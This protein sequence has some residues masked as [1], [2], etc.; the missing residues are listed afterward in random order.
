[1]SQATTIA[2]HSHLYREA[3][4]AITVEQ[5][6]LALMEENLDWVKVAARV[7]ASENT[8]E[9]I[10]AYITRDVL[11]DAADLLA[12]ARKHGMLPPALDKQ[13]PPPTQKPHDD[14]R[15]QCLVCASN[16]PG[17]HGAMEDGTPCTNGKAG[18]A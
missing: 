9:V 14:A 18:A 7:A 6:A 11:I 3:V 16:R 12:V 4:P 5:L 10:K 2:T 8:T 15:W 17:H 1:M 13:P